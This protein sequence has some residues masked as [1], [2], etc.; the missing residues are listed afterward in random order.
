MKLRSVVTVLAL[1]GAIPCVAGTPASVVITGFKNGSVAATITNGGYTTGAS[2]GEFTGSLDGNAFSTFCTDIYQSFSWNNSGNPY[3]YDLKS[4]AETQEMWSVSPYTAGSYSQVSKLY[5]TAYDSIGTSSIKSAAFQFA[6][7]E[8]LY[9]T[10]NGGAYDAGSGSFKVSSTGNTSTAI[11]QA[12][13]WLAA[14]GSAS[15]GYAIQ[16]LYSGPNQMPGN[17]QDFLVATPVPEPETYALALV[18]L[19]IVAGYAK[20]KR[21]SSS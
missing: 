3:T 5:T 2:V 6:L 8:L 15:E 14:L 17:Q 1:A 13:D 11:T 18:S 4:V 20:R 16:S 9:E 10:P 7:W 12:N 21:G 19:G